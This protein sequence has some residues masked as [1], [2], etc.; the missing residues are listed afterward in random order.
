MNNYSLLQPLKDIVI[1]FKLR[2]DGIRGRLIAI[3]Q[4]SLASFRK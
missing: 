1:C 2:Q 4:N 3:A